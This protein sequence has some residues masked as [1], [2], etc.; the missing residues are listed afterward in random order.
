MTFI[1]WSITKNLSLR[2]KYDY[3]FV[4]GYFLIFEKQKKPFLK[5]NHIFA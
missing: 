2:Y 3:E 5:I 4:Y 1:C